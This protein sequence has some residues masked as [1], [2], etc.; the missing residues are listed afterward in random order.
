VF[1][2]DSVV[3]VPLPFFLLRLFPGLDAMRVPG[4]FGLLGAL[5]IAILAAVTLA[6]L[7]R[8]TPRRASVLLGL[9]AI[10]TVVELY[11]RA[12]PEQP[13]KVSE[14]YDVIA[15]HPARGAVLELPIKWSMTQ[16]HVGFENANR[17]FRFLLAQMTHKR[18]IVSGAVSRFPDADREL[19]L[20]T[21]VYRQL[22]AL[23]GEPGFH[24]QADFDGEDLAALG[25]DF[26]V[27]H[28]DD[29]APRV[30]RYVRS[31]GLPVLA[32]DETVIAWVVRG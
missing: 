26:V 27:Y 23:A 6:D 20:A 15:A 2:R 9:A 7:A 5:G 4:R 18:P 32:D 11:P 31:L 14:V 28:R 21:P 12:L 30:L 24:E 25:I 29:P 22:L 10:L 19:L 13:T 16:G 1:V 8:R 3:D 17:D